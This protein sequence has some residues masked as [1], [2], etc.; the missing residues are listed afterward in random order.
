MLKCAMVVRVVSN[1][2]KYNSGKADVNGAIKEKTY[3]LEVRTSNSMDT[4]IYMYFT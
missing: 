4:K 3:N 2:R 1:I